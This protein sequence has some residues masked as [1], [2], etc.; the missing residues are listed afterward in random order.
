VGTDV[1]EA[2]ADAIYVVRAVASMNI[3]DEAVAS[4]IEDAFTGMAKD[5]AAAHMSFLSAT[6]SAYENLA[7]AMDSMGVEQDTSE[8]SQQIAMYANKKVQIAM[9]RK[10]EV[11][12]TVAKIRQIP[13]NERTPEEK[14]FLKEYLENVAPKEKA[15]RDA[16]K[17]IAEGFIANVLG[18]LQGL[19]HVSSAVTD[20][21]GK[22]WTMYMN[23]ED[24]DLIVE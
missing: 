4:A 18:L 11:D 10:I 7:N 23:K 12:L 8:F 5:S 6:Q 3:M 15:C 13:E 17:R 2:M 20:S 24:F 19:D 22:S 9:Q 1:Q 14:A 21:G 16:I